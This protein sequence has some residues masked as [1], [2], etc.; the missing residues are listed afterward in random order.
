MLLCVE[1]YYLLK[2]PYGHIVFGLSPLTPNQYDLIYVRPLI[3]LFQFIDGIFSSRNVDTL[4]FLNFWVGG[5]FL[6]GVYMEGWLV[7]KS[8]VEKPSD[9]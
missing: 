7:L 4:L 8:S 6:L 3:P 2:F 1:Q 9:K 5:P